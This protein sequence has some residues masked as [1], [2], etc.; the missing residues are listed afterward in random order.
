LQNY[1]QPKDVVEDPHGS[2][3]D[4]QYRPDTPYDLEPSFPDEEE[5]EIGDLEI[6][7]KADARSVGTKKTR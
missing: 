2:Y 3:P 7:F 1:K 5:L 6:P 4:P